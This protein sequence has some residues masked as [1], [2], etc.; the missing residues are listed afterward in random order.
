MFP[1]EK[2]FGETWFPILRMGAQ[3]LEFLLLEGQLAR[4]AEFLQGG[5]AE[6]GGQFGELGQERGGFLQR[7]VP[8]ALQDVPDG[9]GE[10]AGDGHGGFVLAAAQGDGEAPLLQGVDGGE[11]P[12]AGLDEQGAQAAAAVL[13]QGAAAFV[14]AAFDDAGVEAEVADELL[15]VGEARDVADDGDQGIG[16]DEVEPGE[17]V[18]AQEVGRL[19]DLQGH[20]PAQPGAAFAGGEQAAV[21][22]AEQQLL[23]R[24]PVLQGEQPRAGFGPAEAEAFGQAQGVFVEVTAQVLLGAG[25]VFDAALVGAE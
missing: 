21:H 18:E 24:A 4:V 11:E 3:H 16:G 22:F 7:L 15:A 5:H 8:V 14:V 20:H 17:L 2:G 6:F 19:V 12:F 25:A 23:A 1:R 10:L 13:V 9:D